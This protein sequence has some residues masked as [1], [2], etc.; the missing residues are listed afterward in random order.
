MS[1]CCCWLMSS[2]FEFNFS[3]IICG[4]N[5]YFVPKFSRSLFCCRIPITAHYVLLTQLSYARW[6]T[7][8]INIVWRLIDASKFYNSRNDARRFLF[9]SHLRP[10]PISQ[11]ELQSGGWTKW[12]KLF[13]RQKNTWKLFNIFSHRVN[14]SQPPSWRWKLVNNRE[15]SNQLILM[16]K[17]CPKCP[18]YIIWRIWRIWYI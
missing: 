6:T 14:Q 1:T 15:S 9:S 5:K 7:N 13:S 2:L 3:K 10:R 18:R 16:K 17:L 11:I 8:I 4:T 12:E